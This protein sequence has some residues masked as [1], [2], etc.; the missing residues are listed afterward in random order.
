MLQKFLKWVA[1]TVDIV[2][3][4]F[5]FVASGIIRFGMLKKCLEVPRFLLLLMQW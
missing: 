1:P 5:M 2:C 3:Y 4:K